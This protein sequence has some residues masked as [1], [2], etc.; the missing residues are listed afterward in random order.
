MHIKN[1]FCFLLLVVCIVQ[2]LPSGSAFAQFSDSFLSE[3]VYFASSKVTSMDFGDLDPS[4]PGWEIAVLTK[5]GK[6]TML[7]PSEG[8]WDGFLVV[9]AG[10]A[11]LGSFDRATVSVGDL[12]PGI[13]GDE[14]AVMS[15]I[16]L[17]VATR[18]GAGS[19]EVERIYDAYGLVGEAWGA[20]V[21]DYR[22]SHPGDEV[23]LIFEGV[24][25]FSSGTVFHFAEDQW[26]SEVVYQ[27]EVGMD[28]TVGELDPFHPG[29]EVIITTEMGPTY[30]TQEVIHTPSGG[31]P[32]MTVWDDIDL[33]GWVCTVADVDDSWAGSEVVYGTRYNNSILV[34]Y[35]YGPEIHIMDLIF[36]GENW[37]QPRN[38]FDVATGHLLPE[39]ACEEIVGVD[40]SGRLYLVYRDQDVWVGETLWSD[41]ADSLYS[42]VVGDFLPESPRDEIVVAGA[43]GKLALIRWDNISA[44]FPDYD[45]FQ[46]LRSSLGNY[47][48]PF[49]PRATIQFELAESAEVGLTIHS[50]DG[51]LIQRLNQGELGQG[52]HEFFWRGNDQQGHRMASGTY[53]YRL[54]VRGRFIMGRMALIK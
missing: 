50:L 30:Q 48:N 3:T 4:R 22:P 1:G 11:S 31:W 40:Q 38:M 12:K 54:E 19:W 35:P 7:T 26:L 42:V 36:T 2:I 28:S 10:D 52:V 37:N 51:R 47:P 13:A 45:W 20:R 53:F 15:R 46:T 14:I 39:S 6:V 34:S 27:G 21:G 43:S 49:N 9:P 16:F 23:F 5:D 25:D 41:P 32:K 44:T 33:A 17:N 8:L 29:P 24:L 18:I